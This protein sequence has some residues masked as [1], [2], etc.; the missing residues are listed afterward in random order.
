MFSL[1]ITAKNHAMKP[2]VFISEK[3]IENDDYANISK[4][5][6]FTFTHV[7]TERTYVPADLLQ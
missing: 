1:K 7:C 2:H 4:D 3:R 5:Q 6:Y